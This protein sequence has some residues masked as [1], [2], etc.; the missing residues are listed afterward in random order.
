MEPGLAPIGFEGIL[1]DQTKS[2]IGFEQYEEEEEKKNT[3]P[4]YPP[5][6]ISNNLLIMN[7][8]VHLKNYKLRILR[9]LFYFDTKTQFTCSL[10]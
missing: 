10:L 7:V 3:M 6:K 4:V 1:F 5:G 8:I 9:F 2:H